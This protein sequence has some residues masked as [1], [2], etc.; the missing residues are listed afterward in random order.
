[1]NKP[2]I[3]G[4]CHGVNLTHR[5]PKDTHALVNVFCED[6]G[7]WNKEMTFSS[8]W[9]PELIAVLVTAQKR[10]EANGVKDGKGN[11]YRLTH[12]HVVENVNQIFTGVN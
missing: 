9:L 3:E 8:Y 5:G 1:M 7:T 11:G 2:Q 6:D 10:L 12:K 4:D